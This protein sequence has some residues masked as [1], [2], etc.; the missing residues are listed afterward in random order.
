MVV[1]FSDVHTRLT[2]A[3]KLEPAKAG[4]LVLETGGPSHSSQLLS[5]KSLPD[6]GKLV[7]DVA[8]KKLDIRL[9]IALVPQIEIGQHPVHLGGRRLAR[10]DQL[11]TAVEDALNNI[12]QNRI[13]RASENQ[14]IDFL[15]LE[16][17]QVF[18]G[19]QPRRLAVDPS[20][21]RQRNKERTRL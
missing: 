6:L 12:T 13:M 19:D 3:C 4:G 17:K 18:P 21:L 10:I 20:L 11:G 5:E 7:R 15:E 16:G 2:I 1:V 14:C 8:D 9:L